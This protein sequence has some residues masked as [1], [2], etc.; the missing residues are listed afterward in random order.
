MSVLWTVLA[1]RVDTLAVLR[2]C[3]QLSDGTF[4][5]ATENFAANKKISKHL[6][7]LQVQTFHHRCFAEQLQEFCDKLKCL[8]M[9]RRT[10]QPCP[11]GPETVQEP[12]QEKGGRTFVYMSKILHNGDLCYQARPIAHPESVHFTWPTRLMI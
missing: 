12:W 3:E 9:C 8:T 7:L 2:R 6:A 5:L 11:T 1:A 10:K 4:K